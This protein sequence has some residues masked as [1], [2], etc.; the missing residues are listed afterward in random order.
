MGLSGGTFQPTPLDRTDPRVQAGFFPEAPTDV[1]QGL[2]SSP[3]QSGPDCAP[4]A[5]RCLGLSQTITGP[6][7]GPADLKPAHGSGHEGQGH[8]IILNTTCLA[9]SVPFWSEL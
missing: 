6:A 3:F 4:V 7:A 1:R 5:P 8:R 9:Q 2:L